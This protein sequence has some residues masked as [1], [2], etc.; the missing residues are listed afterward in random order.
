[1]FGLTD[2]HEFYKNRWDQ[3]EGYTDISILHFSDVLVG[4]AEKSVVSVGVAMS[5]SAGGP[6]TCKL[7]PVL[8]TEELCTLAFVNQF[9]S[10]S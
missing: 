2:I 4:T 1:V 9:R 10:Y 6:E 5:R 8:L 3:F 7:Q